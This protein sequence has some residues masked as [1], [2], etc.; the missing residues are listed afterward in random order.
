MLWQSSDY[1]TIELPLKKLKSL[2]VKTP[3]TEMPVSDLLEVKGQISLLLVLIIWFKFER[4]GN[5]D[6]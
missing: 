6:R 4:S 2:F 1:D 5:L 3:T